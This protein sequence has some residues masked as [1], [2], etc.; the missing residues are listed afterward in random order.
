MG[1]TIRLL[2]IDDNPERVSRISEQ[3]SKLYPNIQV[4]YPLDLKSL[5][6]FLETSSRERSKYAKSS[7]KPLP[8]APKVKVN[9]DQLIIEYEDG[10]RETWGP[11]IS[12]N[13]KETA[14]QME[15]ELRALNWIKTELQSVLSDLTELLRCLGIPEQNIS[16]IVF[17]GYRS[18]LFS[19]K[20][21]DE[22]INGK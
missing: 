11:E 20:R 16:Y 9:G 17:E 10:S 19:F 6:Q 3:I 5:I 18:L 2:A 4:E 21:I 7:Y 15:M 12:D 1:E 22:S 13:I 14:S 8:D